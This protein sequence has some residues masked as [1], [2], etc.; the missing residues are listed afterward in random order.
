MATLATSL[1]GSLAVGNVRGWAVQASADADTTL[2]ITHG[3]TFAD[4]TND[5][6]QRCMVVFTPVDAAFYLQEWIVLSLTSTTLTLLKTSTAM[7][8]GLADT[9][10]NVYLNYLG[11][12]FQ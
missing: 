5:P 7:G 4:P 11:C 6:S 1:G 3:I 8:T 9:T 12:P 10:F 2:A